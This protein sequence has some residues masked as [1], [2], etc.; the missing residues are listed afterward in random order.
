MNVVDRRLSDIGK[1]ESMKLILR[2]QGMTLAK[3]S[4]AIT[5]EIGKVS[6][7]PY[8]ESRDVRLGVL[9]MEK[10]ALELIEDEVYDALQIIKVEQ[11]RYVRHGEVV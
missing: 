4:M 6:V 1:F 5:A 3:E 7:M 8:T 2:D 11:M 9:R 10:M